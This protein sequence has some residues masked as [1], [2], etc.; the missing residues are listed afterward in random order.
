LTQD[1]QFVWAEQDGFTGEGVKKGACV[2]GWQGTKT[3]VGEVVVVV[4]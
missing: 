2:G 4:L 1:E 3:D